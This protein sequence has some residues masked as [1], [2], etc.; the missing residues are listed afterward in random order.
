[1]SEQRDIDKLL[2][3]FK[4]GYR[5]QYDKRDFVQKNIDNHTQ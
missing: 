5:I 3:L 4:V 2:R 1:M